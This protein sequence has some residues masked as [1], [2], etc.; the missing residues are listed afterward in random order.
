VKVVCYK[1]IFRNEADP[2]YD[3]LYPPE[4]GHEGGV[5]FVCFKDVPTP[6]EENGWKILP[7]HFREG[8]PRLRARLHKVLPHVLFPDAAYSLWLDGVFTPL[9]PMSALVA[10]YGDALITTH[11][12]PNRSCVYAEASA[13]AKRGKDDPSR[14]RAAVKY[15]RALGFP[16]NRGLAETGAILR[17]HCDL[18]RDFN[19][20]WRCEIEDRSIRD[21]LSF[22]V[23]RWAMKIPSRY[24]HGSTRNSPHFRWR[25]HHG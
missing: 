11:R 5:E 25:P 22:D 8:S 7:A 10:S 23:V 16:R 3:V 13:I 4:C 21:Q 6:R 12:H 20:R 9:T 1:A 18:V 14:V 24:F 17:K 19:V 15:Y 2:S